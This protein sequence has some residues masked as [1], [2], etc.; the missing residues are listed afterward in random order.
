MPTD[1][2]VSFKVTALNDGGE[3]FPSE[4]LS[5]GINS[6]A[7]AK[8]VLVVN[9]FDRLSAPDDFRSSDDEMAGFLSD[10]DNGVADQQLIS[11]T[12]AQKEFR[13]AIPWTH[14]DAS[15]FGDSYANYERITIAGNT[16]DYPAL[17]GKSI[18]KAG[19]SFV[20]ASRA[21]IVSAPNPSDFAAIDLILGKEKQ[22]K[23]GRE[24]LRPLSFKTFDATT[25]QWLTDWCKAGG[26]VF[27]SGSYVGTDLWQNPLAKS[28]QADRDFAKN[29]LKY[30]WREDRAATT[31]GIAYIVSPLVAD[32]TP[33]TYY[34]KPNSQ[35]YAVES[36]DAIEPA[37]PE[38]YTAFRYPENGLSAGVVFGGNATDKWR[39]CVLAFPFESIKDEAVRDTLMK[40]ILDYLKPQP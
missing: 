33:F 8:P 19:Y 9:G 39:T 30:Q 11:Y 15:G 36:P 22:S 4:I 35:S 40:R 23:L 32:T 34:N 25:Q 5:V 27:V 2:I 21:S 37:C 28:D 31:G 13:R 17:H 20:S 18:M 3:S 10:Y 12:G 14:D 38:A 1:V 7:T 6:K 16:F 24:G 29:I 26:P